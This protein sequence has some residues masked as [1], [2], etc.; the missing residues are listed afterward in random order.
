M[1][2]SNIFEKEL[3]NIVSELGHVNLV[4]MLDQ[5]I[6]EGWILSFE[7]FS[8]VS[9]FVVIGFER[10]IQN[11]YVHLLHFFLLYWLLLLSDNI[12]SIV[13]Q[14][15][16]Q[17]VYVEFIYFYNTFKNC[18]VLR[19]LYRSTRNYHILLLICQVLHKKGLVCL[20]CLGG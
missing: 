6:H 13:L 2:R 7:L 17:V 14:I 16:H 9:L 10:V 20:F 8:Q 4:D 19:V 18:V 12:I 15:L 11:I 5:Y 3:S 1:I